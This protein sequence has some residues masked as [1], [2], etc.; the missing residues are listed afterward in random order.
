MG[1]SLVCPSWIVHKGSRKLIARS[2]RSPVPDKREG[3]VHVAEGAPITDNPVE[4]RFH[5]GWRKSTPQPVGMLE[6]RT[7]DKT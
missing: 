2:Q 4:A 1:M 6:W 7:H 3:V 5:V